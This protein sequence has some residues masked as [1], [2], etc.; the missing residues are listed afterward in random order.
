MKIPVR[1]I[2]T[3]LL[4]LCLRVKREGLLEKCNICNEFYYEK[5]YLLAVDCDCGN[6]EPHLHLA[7]VPIC[8]KCK[9]SV[10]W[11]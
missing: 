8:D 7:R 2:P 3:E 6:K 11:K 1:D 4:I 5:E 10:W 9:N